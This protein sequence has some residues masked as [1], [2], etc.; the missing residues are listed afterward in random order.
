MG[1]LEKR[2]CV[3]RENERR[4]L[5]FRRFGVWWVK[6]LERASSHSG[7]GRAAVERSRRA[8][9][10]EERDRKEVEKKSETLARFASFTLSLFRCATRPAG[11]SKFQARSPGGVAQDLGLPL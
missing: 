1:R 11:H 2:L 9:G 4:L 3:K 6:G 5:C 10:L 7:L 8:W